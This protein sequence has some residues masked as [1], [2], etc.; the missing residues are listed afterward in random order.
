M[1]E[2]WFKI[3]S[4]DAF[5]RDEQ[6]AVLVAML[7]ALAVI[8][9]LE[10]ARDRS[11]PPLYQ[12]G[13]IYIKEPAGADHW[14]DIHEIRRFGGGDCEDLVAWRVAELRASGERARFG[15]ERYVM[16]RDTVF[17]IFVVHAD[18]STEDPS[19][20]LGMHGDA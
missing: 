2:P 16:G 18:G 3:G 17:H 8:N 12:S 13:C 14:L 10:L 6:L 1:Y 11:I 19:K 4:F 7:E 20:L 15:V 5:N 9:R